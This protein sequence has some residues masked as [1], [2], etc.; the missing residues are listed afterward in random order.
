MFI[1]V[2]IDVND[3]NTYYFDAKTYITAIHCT[4]HWWCCSLVHQGLP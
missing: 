3:K 1:A 4:V 2:S